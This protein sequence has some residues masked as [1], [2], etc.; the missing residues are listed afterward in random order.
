MTVDTSKYSTTSDDE[1]KEWAFCVNSF[2]FTVDSMYEICRHR[3]NVM[4]CKEA[5]IYL[6]NAV[7]DFQS[8]IESIN[9]EAQWENAENRPQAVAWEVKGAVSGRKLGLQSRNVATI[10]EPMDRQGEWQVVQ[11]RAKRRKTNS[12]SGDEAGDPNVT[13]KKS[14]NVFERLSYGQRPPSG[15]GV[16]P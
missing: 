13:P 9:L 7:R 3:N 5:I 6:S 2:K 16:P 12:D 15:R 14:A 4:G 11:S 1:A 8:L 10:T